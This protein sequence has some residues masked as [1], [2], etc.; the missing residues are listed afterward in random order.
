MPQM[1]TGS[2]KLAG[3]DDDDFEFVGPDEPVDDI[4]AASADSRDRSSA[5][6]PVRIEPPKDT[7]EI[8]A[9]ASPL[10]G[11][12]AETLSPIPSLTPEGAKPAKAERP[13]S[14]DDALL[15]LVTQDINETR[16]PPQEAEHHGRRSPHSQRRIHHLLPVRLPFRGQGLE[17]RDERKCPRCK[18]PF[19]VPIDPP[20]YSASKKSAAAAADGVDHKGVAA[21][22]S[23]AAGAYSGWMKDLHLHTVSPDKLKLKADS[24]L[25]EFTEYDV[26]FSSDGLL[27]VKR[28]QEGRRSVRAA[29]TRRSRKLAMRCCRP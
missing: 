4:L 11:A 8:P 12:V 14:E 13:K 3:D 9:L 16:R 21:K 19:I 6:E 26:A 24:L 1:D 25:K 29:A 20:D 18:A 5:R 15:D 2:L 17:P 28:R 10:G 27:L 22:A 7:S 23:D